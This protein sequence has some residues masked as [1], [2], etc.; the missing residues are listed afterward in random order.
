MIVV[1]LNGRLSFELGVELGTGGEGIVHRLVDND[2][3]VV[4]LSRVPTTEGWF[5]KLQFMIENAPL[6]KPR[7]DGRAALAWP[8]DFVRGKHSRQPIGFVMPYVTGQTW[9]EF[10]NPNRSHVR[11]PVLRHKLVAMYNLA[12]VV[13]SAHDKSYVVGDI[14]RKNVLVNR[15]GSVSV[16]DTDSF[17]VWDG[18]EYHSCK[19]AHPEYVAPEISGTNFGHVIRSY[20][21]DLF[22]LAVLMFQALHYGS[23][24]YRVIP[25]QSNVSLPT[26]PKALM[27]GWTAVHNG[28]SGSYPWLRPRDCPP[29]GA[30]P[31][32]FQNL[33]VRA[34][35][36]GHQHPEFRPSAAEWMAAIRNVLKNEHELRECD[37]ITKHQVFTKST[38]GCYECAMMTRVR[39]RRM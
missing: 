30:L 28:D 31:T 2:L 24:P 35:I 36:D 4:K 10:C 32:E 23:H 18:V 12:Y 26:I 9:Y 13:K 19:V 3:Q 11:R 21:S 16:I 22:G 8:T 33:F 14:N 1:T 20:Q 37:G 29:L 27:N 25:V 7:P 34:F 5:K 17:Q 15:S 39:S 6:L 38:I